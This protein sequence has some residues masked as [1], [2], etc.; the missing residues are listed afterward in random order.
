M[1]VVALRVRVDPNGG[2]EVAA[3]PRGAPARRGRVTEDQVQAVQNAAALLYQ[4]DDQDPAAWRR[5]ETRVGRALAGI[6]EATPHVARTWYEALGAIEPTGEPGVVIADI[7]PTLVDLPWE[8]LA[9]TSSSEPL[10]RLGIA[11]VAR[12]TQ[13]ARTLPQ[14]GEDDVTWVEGRLGPSR[15]LEPVDNALRAAW[16]RRALPGPVLPGEENGPHIVTLIADAEGRSL[17]SQA[18]TGRAVGPVEAAIIGAEVAWL[19]LLAGKERFDAGMEHVAERAV[20]KG[21][22]S[23]LHSPFRQDLDAAA[24]F[25]SALLGALASGLPV[26]VATL[27]ARAAVRDLDIPDIGGRWWTTRWHIGH[28]SVVRRVPCPARYMPPGWPQPGE[29]AAELMLRAHGFGEVDGFLGVE[30]LA[31]ATR[32]VGAH[33]LGPV[34]DALRAGTPIW[35]RRI[36]ALVPQPIARRPSPP[37]TPRLQRLGRTLQDGFSVVDL[38]GA[39]LQESWAWGRWIDPTRE[40]LDTTLKP[41]E[42]LEVLGGPEDGRRLSLRVSDTIGRFAPQTRATHTLYIHSPITD[43]RLSRCHIE[44]VAPGSFRLLAPARYLRLQDVEI[45][46]NGEPLWLRV[47]ELLELTPSTAFVGV[48]VT[49]S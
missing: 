14:L 43:R 15:I 30:H 41:A 39:I 8:L 18:F 35:R 29:E 11:T 45:R 22:L 42:V 24:G 47:G 49:T 36:E 19:A 48:D 17:L 20:R 6:I 13:G 4:L 33:G 31:E 1:H 40:S 32:D 44:W 37:P 26:G 38:W 9:A 25:G 23:C 34:A 10:D 46:D 12:F 28:P 27:I 7:D 2:W 3:A 5:A 21:A 16:K